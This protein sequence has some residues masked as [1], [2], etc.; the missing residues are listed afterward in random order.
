[1]L[2]QIFASHGACAGEVEWDL[3]GDSMW[4]HNPPMLLRSAPPDISRNDSLRV[5]CRNES[6]G[7]E[8]HR[9]S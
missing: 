9:E 6:S 8:A 7:V 2:L 5:L 3:A 4:N 1:M